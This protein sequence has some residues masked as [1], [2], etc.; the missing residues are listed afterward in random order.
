MQA[1]CDPS[2]LIW[3][4]LCHL[5]IRTNIIPLVLKILLHAVVCIF[6]V[7]HQYLMC[8]DGSLLLWF[9]TELLSLPVI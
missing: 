8:T 7:H 5:Q 4:K 9:G 6:V 1:E 3:K 2:G